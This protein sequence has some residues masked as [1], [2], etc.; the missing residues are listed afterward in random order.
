MVKEKALDKDEFIKFKLNQFEEY[1]KTDTYKTALKEF[2]RD[3]ENDKKTELSEN[4]TKKM[5]KKEI[6]AL[7]KEYA[8]PPSEDYMDMFFLMSKK[9]DF[10]IVDY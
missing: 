8:Q 9:L 2:I 5:S 4:N 1:K 6:E 7:Q 10:V 3:W